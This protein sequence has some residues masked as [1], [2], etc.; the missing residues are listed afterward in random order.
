M[1]AAWRLVGQD[2]LAGEDGAGAGEETAGGAK[3]DGE[4][5]GEVE[6]ELEEVGVVGAGKGLPRT[7]RT[8]WARVTDQTVP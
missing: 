8:V 1:S 6:G 4:E 2:E 5:D 3:A 7:R